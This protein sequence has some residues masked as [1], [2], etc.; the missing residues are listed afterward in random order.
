MKW[1]SIA[2]ETYYPRESRTSEYTA[3]PLNTQGAV[4]TRRTIARAQ[5]NRDPHES[6]SKPQ[7]LGIT[8]RKGKRTL[9]GKHE[10]AEEQRRVT[11]HI[12]TRE[13]SFK[14]LHGVLDLSRQ[15]RVASRTYMDTAEL[16][17]DLDDKYGS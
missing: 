10:V 7:G 2:K 16:L 12:K 14:D 9:E 11:E 15:E 17:E 1:R 13:Q 6:T 4:Y 3:E 5:T 8:A